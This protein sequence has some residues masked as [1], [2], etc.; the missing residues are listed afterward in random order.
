MKNCILFR[1]VVVEEGAV[2]ENCVLMQNTHVGADCHVNCVITDKDVT[3]SD[4]RVLAGYTSYPFVVGKGVT[5]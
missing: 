1:D 5:V 3:I 2:L 4:G